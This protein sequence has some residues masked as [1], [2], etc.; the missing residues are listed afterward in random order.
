[1][2][3][4]NVL[5]VIFGTFMVIVPC[6][7]QKSMQDLKILVFNKTG[8]LGPD[9]KPTTAEPIPAVEAMLRDLSAQEGFQM[10]V[11]LDSTMF[12]D[13]TLAVYDISLQKVKNNFFR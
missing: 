4:K 7:A 10:T 5:I 8:K 6:S 2:N 1:M 11:T 3:I 13:D 9:G 12:N